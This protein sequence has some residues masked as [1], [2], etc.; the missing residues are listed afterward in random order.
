M[1]V[2]YFSTGPSMLEAENH[3]EMLRRWILTFPA[4]LLRDIA[5]GYE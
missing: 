2:S 4:A 3:A 5:W 1:L